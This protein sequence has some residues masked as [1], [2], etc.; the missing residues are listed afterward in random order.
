VAADQGL[1]GR[2]RSGYLAMRPGAR[3]AL[4]LSVPLL[5]LVV[6]YLGSIAVMLVSAFW[7]VNDFTGAVEQTFTFDN[8]RRLV[9]EPLFATVALRTILVALGVTVIDAVFAI[10]MALFMSKVASPRLRLGL[11][12]AVTTPLWASYLVKAYAWRTLVAPNGPIAFITGGNTPGY[13]LAATVITLAYLWLPYMIIPIYAGFDRVSDSLVEASFDLGAS[14]WRT[15]RSVALPLVFPAIA[16]GSI[17]TVSLTLGD[18]IAVGIVGGKTQLLA[19]VI[20]GQLVTANN[21]PFAAALSLIPLAAIVL[22]LF[23]M[24]RTGALENV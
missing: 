6:M 20:Y 12:V 15:I 9:T 14:A 21:Q 1:I 19:N 8:I 7:T 3:L 13:G 24:R 5:W 16:A 11:L 18:Y 10:P 22:Y 23:A 2:Q 17:F 4:L